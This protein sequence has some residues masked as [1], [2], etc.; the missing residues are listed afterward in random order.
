MEISS[1]NAKFDQ[2][3]NALVPFGQQMLKEYGEFYPFGM[4]MNLK[5]EIIATG[6]N[7]REGRPQSK[8]VIDSLIQIFQQKKRNITAAGIAFDSTFENAN[9]ESTNAISVQ[10][11][12]SDRAVLILIPYKKG[13]TGEI[14]YDEPIFSKSE[15]T[16]SLS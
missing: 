10:L 15:C 16:F 6:E 7:L 3:L 1:S 9:K 13:D 5:G 2:L 4:Y 14:E 11:E 12:D 8:L